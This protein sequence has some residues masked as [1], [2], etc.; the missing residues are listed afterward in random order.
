ML[1]A[2]MF[3]HSILVLIAIGA[4]VRVL[5]GLLRGEAS[6]RQCVSFIRYSLVSNLIGLAFPF[7]GRAL[8]IRSL[9][10]IA[11]YVT[12]LVLLSWKCFH[13]KGLWRAFFVLGLTVVLG[14]E[15]QLI[16]YDFFQGAMPLVGMS[17]M[18]INAAVFLIESA[19]ILAYLTLAVVAAYRCRSRE[20]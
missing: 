19:V 6:C 12:G 13:L 4:G 8:S 2:L 15:V 7:D 10:M 14:I 20:A 9:S 16:L 3:V 17:H 1:I 18:R 11:I 5:R